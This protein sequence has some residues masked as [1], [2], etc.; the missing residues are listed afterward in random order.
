MFEGWI[1]FWKTLGGISVSRNE[2]VLVWLERDLKRGRTNRLEQFLKDGGDINV[3]IDNWRP[4]LDR[5]IELHNFQATKILLERDARTIT[6]FEFNAL[7]TAAF[8]GYPDVVRLLLEHGLDV[9]SVWM[10]STTPLHE[11]CMMRCGHRCPA[12]DI[13]DAPKSPAEVDR[14][15]E[16]ARILLA[17]GADIHAVCKDWPGPE[18][19]YRPLHFAAESNCLPMVKLMLENGADIGAKASMGS[20]AHDVARQNNHVEVAE[21]LAAH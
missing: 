16:T 9:N 2:K 13:A 7:C 3:G 8:N 5:A 20:T 11:A 12:W 17:A 18:F 4:V 10:T 19:E 1:V 15:L 21:Y 14:F 6:H